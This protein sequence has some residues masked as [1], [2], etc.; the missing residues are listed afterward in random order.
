MADPPP[1]EPVLRYDKWVEE[2]LCHVIRRALAQVAEDGLPDPHH[3]FI[4]FLTDAPGVVM[5][6]S[7]RAQYPDKITIV[8]QHQF[9]GL[10]VEDD[11]FEVTLAFQGV[12]TPL[13]IPF[14]AITAFA[15]PG[16]NFGL[17]LKVSEMEAG[18]EAGEDAG[19]APAAPDGITKMKGKA[20]AKPK[21]RIP[22]PV[23]KLKDEPKDEATEPIEAEAPADTKSGEV[24]TLDTFRKK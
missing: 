15:D 1:Q 14:D 20:K 12:N 13:R 9:W 24:I 16:V 8:L 4:T 18:E 11:A 5:P 22:Q 2:A 10:A 3:F 19:E 23:A 17:Q 7:L 21:P 6:K